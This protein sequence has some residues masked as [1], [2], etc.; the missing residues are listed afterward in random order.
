MVSEKQAGPNVNSLHGF[1]VIDR[2]KYQLEE[3]C[4][5]IVSCADILAI[6]ARDAVAVVNVHIY[7]YI[8]IHTHLSL[9]AFHLT[10][11]SLY[12][13]SITRWLQ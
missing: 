5:L 3:A 13:S 4:P 11:V 7:I 12:I 10:T 2:I 9:S 8:Y 1:E 6:A